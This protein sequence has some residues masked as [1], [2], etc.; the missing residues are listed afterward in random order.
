[1]TLTGHHSGAG[2]DEA[3]VSVNFAQ[4]RA[5]H[6][7]SVPVTAL[8]AVSGGNYALQQAA[9]PHTLI[10][11]TVGLFAAGYVQVSGAGIHPGLHVTDSQG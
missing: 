10:P 6:V 2:L 8:V 5:N 9:A 7:L 4:H 1:M 3:A 11:V